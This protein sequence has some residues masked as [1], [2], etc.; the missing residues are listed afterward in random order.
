[1]PISTV[2]RGCLKRDIGARLHM[3]RGDLD[4]ELAFYHPRGKAIVSAFVAGVNAHIAETARNP[5]LLPLE[6]SLL[7][8]KPGPWTPAVVISRHQGLLGTG[9]GVEID[10]A[11]AVQRT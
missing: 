4:Q 7:G 9:P 2:R 1:M 3:F 6:F 10:Y 11:K 8:I 5:K